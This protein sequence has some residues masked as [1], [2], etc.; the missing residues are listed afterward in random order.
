MRRWLQKSG[1]GYI[2][3]AGSSVGAAPESSDAGRIW[4]R[5]G[6]GELAVLRVSAMSPALREALRGTFERAPLS[7]E[8][9]RQYLNRH[10]VPWDFS[11]AHHPTVENVSV[12]LWRVRDSAPGPGGVLY[13]AWRASGGAA[14]VTLFRVMEHVME[15]GAPLGE[16]I[17]SRLA[18]A[19]K[20]AGHGDTVE[21]V[22]GAKALGPLAL[23]NT[24][25]RRDSGASAQAGVS[26]LGIGG[27]RGV[28]PRAVSC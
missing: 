7:A 16:M 1:L 18:F 8:T 13:G 28:Y 19:P 2:L 5:G 3:E 20:G 21:V 12:C 10:A 25:G 4:A 14:A 24:D 17:A 15:G 6:E 23:Q 9:C 22:R 11:G 26:G 27:S